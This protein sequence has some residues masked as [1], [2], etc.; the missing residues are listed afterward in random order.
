[1]MVRWER[2]REIQAPGLALLGVALAFLPSS[3]SYIFAPPGMLRKAVAVSPVAQPAMRCA[4]QLR[5]AS[6]GQARKG[7][8]RRGT[9]GT[10]NLMAGYEGVEAELSEDQDQD[11]DPFGVDDEEGP[12]FDKEDLVRL[13]VRPAP[14]PSP[15]PTLPQPGVR[16]TAS[17]MRGGLR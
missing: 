17:A 15:S 8:W 10:L 11:S 3:S 5:G 13:K 7:G 12:R 1:M 6:V 4:G 2:R 14:S 16:A 9:C